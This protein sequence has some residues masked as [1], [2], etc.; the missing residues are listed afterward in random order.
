V[1]D[2]PTSGCACLKVSYAPIDNG[3]GTH[4]ELWRC[5]LC[6]S[7]FQRKQ[8]PKM[9]ET[10][11]ETGPSDEELDRIYEECSG[12]HRESLRKVYDARRAPGPEREALD[13]LDAKLTAMRVALT[14]AGIPEDE[15]YS[16]N[17]SD[18]YER[19]LRAGG[20]MLSGV[21][22]IERLAAERDELKAGRASLAGELARVNVAWS[23]QAHK[24]D[25]ERMQLRAEL[26]AEKAAHEST[27]VMLGAVIRERDT[28]RQARVMPSREA[29]ARRLFETFGGTWP[30][31][32]AHLSRIGREAWETQAD[33]VLR[34]LAPTQDSGPVGSADR[35]VASV[36][37]TG[38]SPEA[39]AQP[40][41][42]SSDPPVP[43]KD[44]VEVC[45]YIRSCVAVGDS[46]EKACR[47]AAYVYAA[48]E[49]AQHPQPSERYVPSVGERAVLVASPDRQDQGLIGQALEIVATWA[50]ADLDVYW[51]TKDPSG[52]Q[53]A[54]HRDATWCRAEP[55]LSQPGDAAA[56]VAA[57]PRR[58]TTPSEAIECLRETIAEE[59]HQ[60][61][62]AHDAVAALETVE[63]LSE[64]VA[65]V[66]RRLR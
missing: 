61:H 1:T 42:A 18:E 40:T 35:D 21:E 13:D 50:S 7:K 49:P 25:S 47:N 64:R 43:E 62:P 5:N 11:A 31:A 37:A 2:Q 34:L 65:A 58:F 6:G 10:Q 28:A 29:L 36:A 44:I 45:E 38:S 56:G 54:I 55:Q 63:A 15:P 23:N 53:R 3:N 17:S 8:E 51:D 59:C 30:S 52:A 33:A 57:Q 48:E 9:T 41:G 24:A 19:A 46:L 12:T 14:R 4:S 20:R 32:W 22:R 60:E 66:E 26:E 16:D 27:S 39:A